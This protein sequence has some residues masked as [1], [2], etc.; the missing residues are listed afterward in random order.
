[1]ALS[2]EMGQPPFAP[3][4]PTD[5]RVEVVI[6]LSDGR[7]IVVKDKTYDQTD[8]IVQRG[9]R[10]RR[11]VR[12]LCESRGKVITFNPDHVVSIEPR[13]VK[14]ERESPEPYETERL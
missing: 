13:E 12:L 7:T 14:F 1:M 4:E 5:N 2:R 6:H 3:F 11:N 10:W 8:R 9:K